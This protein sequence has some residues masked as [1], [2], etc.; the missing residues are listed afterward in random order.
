MSYDY[1]LDSRMMEKEEEEKY[2]EMCYD[3]AVDCQRG[4]YMPQAFCQMYDRPDNVSKEDWEICLI[5]PYKDEERNVNEEYYDAWVEITDNAEYVDDNKI[6]RLEF[7]E[8]GDLLF[9]YEF[10]K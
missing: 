1:F 6:T 4:I 5:G 10:L 7:N 3:V 2:A 9:H 8:C